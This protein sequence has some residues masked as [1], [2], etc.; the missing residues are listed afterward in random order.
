VTDL[1][2]QLQATLG[3]A[4]TIDRE[5][6]G[7]GMSRVFAGTEAALGRQ[8][9]I[10]AL[11]ADT[12]NAVSIERFKRE[13]S[14]VARLQH[15][16]IVPILTAGESEGIPFY[17]MPFVKGDSLRARLASKGP[18]TIS[19]TVHVLRDVASALA[20]AH[21]E[22]VVHRD[23]K[24][25][26][27]I[28]SGGVAVVTDFGVAKALDVATHDGSRESGSLTSMGMA[29]GTPAYMSPEQ[30]T[31]EPDVDHRADIYSF[32][33]IAYEMLTGSSPFAGRSSQQ[34]IAA[35]VT[36][37]PEPIAAR[38]ADVPPVLA[39][40]VTRCLEKDRNVRPGSAEELIAALDALA[41]PSGETQ[42]GSRAAERSTKRLMIGIGAMAVL[43]VGA[44]AVVMMRR[45][46]AAPVVGSVLQVTRSTNELNF[47]ASISPDGKFVAYATGPA[48][49][50][51]IVVRQV[52]GSS[53]VVL[54]PSLAG[55]Q[56]WPRW[57]PD[58][59]K[60]SF[61]ADQSIYVTGVLGGVPRLVADSGL[62]PSWSPDGEQLTFAFGSNLMT[63]PATGGTPRRIATNGDLS[64]P[65]WSPDGKR[66]A[67]VGENATFTNAGNGSY[68]NASPSSIW[69]VGKDGGDSVRVTDNSNLNVSPA[70]SP[71]GRSIFFASDRDGT[72]DIYRQRLNS[73]GGPA[74][75]PDRITS[76]LEVY[77]FTLNRDGTRMA[78]GTLHLRSN[79]WMVPIPATGSTTVAAA[80][81]V[82]N[83]K[84]AI[85]GIAIS[86]DGKWLAF[87]S[88]RNGNQDVFKVAF[89]GS[90]AVGDPIAL[91]TN[92]S[93]DYEPRWSPDDEEIAF[94]SRRFGTRDVFTVKADGRDE[95][96]VTDMPLQEFY[97]DWSPNGQALVFTT[98]ILGGTGRN[99]VYVTR[100]NDPLHWTPPKRVTDT[101]LQAVGQ[102]ARFLSDTSVLLSSRRAV[103]VLPL[104]GGPT[105]VLVD[106]DSIGERQLFL[107]TSPDRRT[108]YF[109][110]QDSL[111]VVSFWSIAAAGG[112]PR[113][114]LRLDDP[115]H[116]TR[117][118]EFD[119]DGKNLFFTLTA[120][121]ADVAV[122]TL[123]RP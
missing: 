40:L 54:A 1:R 55:D 110:T 80:H 31:A 81:A 44:I 61:T 88:N 45:E 28:V 83:E 119:T 118:I 95:R 37:T 10:K 85:E 30:A 72:R 82:T 4:Y 60:L 116:R 2:A 43:V 66:I 13:I 7:G 33:C 101:T 112:T 73:S 27:V 111:K 67:Y 120:D 59:S 32:G 38:R 104:G 84:Q 5:L 49:R 22:G 17:T 100:R 6:G 99:A 26:N 58:G 8:I 25:E 64:T 71:D 117:R 51:K 46:P 79:I 121:E 62:Q 21:A 78:Y 94:Y 108:V 75:P 74:G 92:P 105:R 57:S 106:F 3:A 53:A 24:P 19:E 69:I 42:A 29:V 50:M 90:V 70:W 47:D 102:N 103:Q 114:I 52:T 65:V 97:P 20:Y 14:V 91:T 16:H 89:N 63:V 68:G 98:S 115:A 77:T 86:H 18:L 9:V 87:D 109:N 96:R 123:K 107:G 48:G 34:L 41:V 15:P 36:T 23:I 113:R 122:A 76:G 12:M 35:H 39:E 56:R 11:P 93:A